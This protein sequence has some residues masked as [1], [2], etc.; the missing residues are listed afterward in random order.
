MLVEEGRVVYR[1]EPGRARPEDVSVL[2]CDGRFLLPA[3][4]DC[5]CHILPAGLDLQKLHLGSCASHAEVLQAVRESEKGLQPGEWLRAVHYD[6]TKYEGGHLHRSQLDAISNERPIL[7]RHAS[8]HASVANSAALAAAGIHDGSPDPEGGEYVRDEGG[9]L[10][11]VLLEKAHEAVSACAPDPTLDQM[12]D[13]IG[14]AAAEMAKKGIACASDMMTGQFGLE[15]EIEAY[16]RATDS[17]SSVRMRL[18]PV[19][20]SVF[21]PKGIGPIVLREIAD[22]L[23]PARLK[24]AGVKIFADGAVGAGTAAIYGTYA[25]SPSK[26][27][28]GTSGQ[29]IYSPERLNEMVRIADEAGWRISIHS[30]GDY[31]TDLV[32]EALEQTANPR[33]HRIEHAMLL[34][35]SQIERLANLGAH[36][37]MQPEFLIRFAHAYRKQLGDERA[38]KIK[39]FRSVKDAGIRLSLSSDWPI[40]TGDPWSAVEA[41]SNRPG[42]FDSSENLSRGEAI[43]AHTALAAEATGDQDFGA[44]APGQLAD[45]NLFGQD[46]LTHTSPNMYRDFGPMA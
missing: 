21:G 38:S 7:L 28:R 45:F 19:W 16:R 43:E 42:G 5:H 46:P 13:A 30:I 22:S 15:T 44:L 8:G 24:I 27:P 40:T 18:Y 11:G 12:V 9:H 35:D 20:S 17:G 1:G 2:D 39:R 31:S 41:A 33:I 36:V 37:S 10:T 29:L 32:M 26:E 14:K 6:Q 4:T 34:S 3:F 25:S 23:D